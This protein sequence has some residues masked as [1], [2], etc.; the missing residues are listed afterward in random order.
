MMLS[1]KAHQVCLDGFGMGYRHGYKLRSLWYRCPGCGRN[2][3]RY[4][5]I[6]P[7]CA[8]DIKFV[9]LEA[10]TA[11]HC[12]CCGKIVKADVIACQGCGADLR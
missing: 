1:T 6:C 4:R 10:N 9:R 12:S 5:D 2:V 3:G 11:Y 7:H 8:M